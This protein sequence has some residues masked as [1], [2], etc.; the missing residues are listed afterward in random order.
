MGIFDFRLQFFQQFDWVRHCEKAG[1]TTTLSV[2]LLFQPELPLRIKELSAQLP[3]YPA[4]KFDYCLIV[5]VNA[6][7]Q[8]F[9]IL[10]YAILDM[11]QIIGTHFLQLQKNRLV[12]FPVLIVP[13]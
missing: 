10:V 8:S 3:I 4:Q 11:I 7:Y 13:S 9:V 2:G 12:E 6:I 1:A 5:L